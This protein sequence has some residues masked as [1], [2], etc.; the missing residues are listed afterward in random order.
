MQPK[1]VHPLCT[2]ALWDATTEGPTW[3]NRSGCECSDCGQQRCSPGAA[4]LFGVQMCPAHL[5]RGWGPL[6]ARVIGLFTSEMA[7][8]RAWLWVSSSSL[9]GGLVLLTHTTAP[10]R[11]VVELR[12][13][14]SS[15]QRLPPQLELFGVDHIRKSACPSGHRSWSERPTSASGAFTDA[16]HVR[17]TPQRLPT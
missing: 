1:R 13:V 7:C 4:A 11:V 12:P 16:A 5:H 9:G 10:G 17:P 14:Q 8:R 6:K 15:R 2:A 3:K